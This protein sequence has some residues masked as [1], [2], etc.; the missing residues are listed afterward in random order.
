MQLLGLGWTGKELVTGGNLEKHLTCHETIA[1][2][3]SDNVHILIGK[4][5]A[6]SAYLDGTIWVFGGKPGTKEYNYSKSGLGLWN[7]RCKLAAAPPI[8]LVM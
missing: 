7:V 4:C 1:V 8:F 5:M 3:N 6:L 2:N